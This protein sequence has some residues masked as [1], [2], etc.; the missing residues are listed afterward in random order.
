MKHL[1]RFAVI[2]ALLLPGCLNYEQH[3]VLSEDGSGTISIHY[4]IAENVMS[5]MESGNLAFTEDKVR[6]QYKGDGVDIESV[7]ITTEAEDST[8]HVRVDLSFNDFAELSKLQSFRNMEFKWLREGDVFRFSQKL[9]ANGSSQDASLDAFK[10]KYSYEFPGDI[11]QSNA[12][13]TDGRKAFWVFNLS[14]MNKDHVITA[15]IS[16][17]SGS[18]V[19]W[20]LGVIGVVVV[21]IVIFAVVRRRK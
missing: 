21:L 2:L 7:S 10:V 19:M 18:S 3:T 20:V 12:D 9:G 15:R 5:W 4:S 6:E 11:L 8:R 1:A 14:E 13:S 17:G 16:A